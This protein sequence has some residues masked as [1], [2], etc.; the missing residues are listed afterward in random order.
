MNSNHCSKLLALLFAT[1]LVVSAVGPAAAMSA[2]ASGAPDKKQVGEDVTST[3]TITKPFS[4]YDTWTLNGTTELKDVTWTVQ[5]YDQGGSKI[6]QKS[7]DG[8]SFDHAL[9]KSDAYE[10]K[11]IVKG[12][13]PEVTN[14]TYDPAQKLTLAE[15]HQV[16]EGGSSEPIADPWTFRPY[17][18][19]SQE[20]RDAIA[21]AQD[22]ID[23][24]ESSGASVS[25]AEDT[26]DN[27][28]SAFDAENFDNAAD[29]ANE[30]EKKAES[31]QQSNQQTQM[32]L[33]GGA[34]LLALVV[35]V[36][37]VLWYRSNQQDDYDKL[38]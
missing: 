25:G 11:V 28:V 7:Y 13:V 4:E 10:V 1:T 6:G 34:G 9:K 2:S 29:F 22:A 18:Q 27:A 5:L 23:A 3:F 32:L 15:L 17:T 19:E 31:S 35:V 8:Q 30:A 36:G 38:R 37:G 12:T 21:S 24:A 16:R 26:L 33:Y 14:F 20:A